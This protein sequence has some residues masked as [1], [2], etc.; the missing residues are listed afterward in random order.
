MF[1][2]DFTGHEVISI[3]E[4]LVV[5]TPQYGVIIDRPCS[6]YEGIGLITVILGFYLLF[7]RK[8][9]AIPKCA[10]PLPMGIALIW[11]AN[12]FRIAAL[13]AMGTWI[14]PEIANGGFHSA[15]G[16]LLFCLI[17]LVL[18]YVSRHS[19]WFALE[20]GKEGQLSNPGGCVPATAAVSDRDGAR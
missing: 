3:P 5:G 20:G 15:A 2:L 10:A 9:P 17:T 6:G 13:I 1:L 14:S 8:F 16:W 18:V 19:E 7:S 4:E 11:I 12:S